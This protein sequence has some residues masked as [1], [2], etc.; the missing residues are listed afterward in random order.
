MFL[1]EGLWSAS[2]ILDEVLP[3]MR[4]NF[5]LGKALLSILV[6]TKRCRPHD[7]LK[8]LRYR[9]MRVRSLAPTEAVGPRDV[10]PGACRAACF[11]PPALAV[12][13][14]NWKPFRSLSFDAH[15]FPVRVVPLLPPP[16]IQV[17]CRTSVVK[18]FVVAFCRVSLLASRFSLR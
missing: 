6:R 11:S 5:K 15:L 7:N 9:S 1:T 12:L 14:S 4:K 16:P 18:F 17:G 2:P 13:V 10:K 8:T 3:M